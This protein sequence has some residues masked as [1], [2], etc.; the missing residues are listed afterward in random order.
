MTEKEALLVAFRSRAALIAEL[1]SY[2]EETE[3]VQQV[4]AWAKSKAA[5]LGRMFRLQIKN[6]HT[7]IA[8]VNKLLRKIGYRAK[9][10]AHLGSDGDRSK[11]WAA[12][13]MDHQAEVWAALESL[14]LK[15]RP[16]FPL[17]DQ[18]Q[19]IY[20]DGD[21]REGRTASFSDLLADWTP[22]GLKMK[23][24]RAQR[25]RSNWRVFFWRR[26]NQ[27]RFDAF[28]FGGQI[29]ALSC[30]RYTIQKPPSLLNAG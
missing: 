24:F 30:D 15:S 4:A 20:I 13:P 7:A 9:A 3:L 26:R 14:A 23:R 12:E 19:I 6:E 11:V 5:M 28:R 21:Y 25:Y 2:T 1:P 29:D 10:I 16:A 17:N 27:D 22:E 8:T 18:W